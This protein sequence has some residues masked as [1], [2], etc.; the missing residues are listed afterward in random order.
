MSGCRCLI[1]SLTSCS[2]TATHLP[3]SH[4]LATLFTG[5]SLTSTENLTGSDKA[6]KSSACVSHAGPA[7]YELCTRQRLGPTWLKVGAGRLRWPTVVDREGWAQAA[8]IRHLQGAISDVCTS[9]WPWG[10]PRATQG[11]SR[12][13]RSTQCLPSECAHQLACLSR[14]CKH[15]IL[16]SD[17]QRE[18]GRE[19]R[20]R[21]GRRDRQ[22]ETEIE[23]NRKKTEYT[24]ILVSYSWICAHV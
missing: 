9:A 5:F 4:F 14:V 16:G 17:Q 15:T 18:G 22:R 12:C 1:C 21:E 8:Q 10:S 13:S 6:L 23:K 11:R 24:C 19:R 20:G 2:P 3:Y 7:G